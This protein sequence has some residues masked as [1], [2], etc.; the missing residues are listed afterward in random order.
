MFGFL[1][2]KKSAQ[3]AKDRLTIAIM[4]DRSQNEYPFM[5]D[6]KK[7]IINVVKKYIEVRSI[8]IKKE[9]QEDL[10]AISI[11]LELEKH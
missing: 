3:I 1:K 8:H 5:E 6:L 7:D 2:K 4:S 9:I 11:D 10:E